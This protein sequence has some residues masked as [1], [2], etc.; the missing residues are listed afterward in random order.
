MILRGIHPLA[1]LFWLLAP[2][3]TVSA[4]DN[5][6][7]RNVIL[8]IGDGMGLAHVSYLRYTEDDSIALDHFPVIGLQKTHS[9]NSLITDSGAA[10][11]AIACGVKTYNNAIGCDIDS[12]FHDNL[13]EL[14]IRRGLKTG[15]VVTSSLVHATPAAFYAH[16]KL[17]GFH[18]GIADNL[19][20]SGIDYFVGGG[21]VYFSNRYGDARNLIEELRNEGYFVSGYDKKSFRS[22]SAKLEP[23]MAYFTAYTEPLPV[24]QGREPLSDIVSHALDVLTYRDTAGF[25]MLVE[26]SQID[27]AS[28]GNDASYLLSELRDFDAAISVA[29][30]YA[31]RRGDTLILVTGDHETGLLTLE[32]SV[33]GKRIH[34]EF[35]T[36]NHSHVLVPVYAYGPCADLFAGLYDNTDIFQ[37][38]REVLGI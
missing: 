34:M 16:Q 2:P 33:P 17:R 14:A 12:V 4:Q 37:K 23:K 22:F 35:L 26:G 6:Q 27:Y 20:H 21:Q 31:R 24:M 38:I 7:V 19:V 3:F 30:D 10:A 36:R 15:L 5:C 9:A 13:F 18:E 25:L 1:V 29:L 8:M 11:T 28:H 32:E